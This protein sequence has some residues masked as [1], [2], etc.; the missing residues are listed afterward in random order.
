MGKIPVYVVTGF[1]GSGKTTF[2]KRVIDAYAGGYKVAVVQNEFAPANID[3]RELRRIA[4]GHFEMLEVNNGSVFCVCLLSGFIQSLKGFVAG[5]HPEMVIMEA[6]G[7]SDPIGI[8]ELFNSPELQEMLYLAGSIC[9]VDGTSFLKLE[10]MQQ[11]MVHQVQI[12]DHVVVNKVDLTGHADQIIEKINSINPQCRK[13]ISS[14]CDVPLDEIFEQAS[15]GRW[16]STAPFDV[17]SGRPDIK[18][19]VFKTT[20]PLKA[21]NA[22][23]FAHSVGVNAIR[24]KGYLLL[25]NGSSIAA[26]GTCGVVQ[27]EPMEF[28]VRQSEIVVMGWELTPRDVKEIY[29]AHCG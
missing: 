3:G 1:L 18:T 29:L 25:D 6:S 20:R 8:G 10:K 26:Q 14:Y 17:A 21:A 11:R 12:A 4:T 22:I 2:V 23:R 24:M 16:T 19:A 15:N 7:L 28:A 9:I 5:H 13:F 27:T